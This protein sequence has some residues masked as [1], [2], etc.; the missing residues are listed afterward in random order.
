MGYALEKSQRL[1]FSEY[2]ALEAASLDSR[3]EYLDGWVYAMAGGTDAHNLIVGNAADSLRQFYRPRGCRVFTETVQ[4]EV[5]AGKRYVYPD[6]FV[7]CS[8]RDQ[9]SRRRKR[10]PILI[11]EVLSESTEKKDLKEK[12]EY[13]QEISSLQAYLIV[14][15]TEYWVRVYERDAEGSWLPHWFVNQPADMLQ[16]R[17]GWS[18]LLSDLYAD[19][20]LH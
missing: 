11:I 12:V 17:S 3:Y 7:T 1:T 8:E 5:Q 14:E 2:E 18:I 19:V 10:E 6:V 16:L 20:N 13:Y 4:V 9:E 15:Q